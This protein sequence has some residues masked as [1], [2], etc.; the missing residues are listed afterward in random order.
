VSP[1]ASAHQQRS[2]SRPSDV[3]T[4][5][6]SRT[7]CAVEPH[8]SR[9]SAM[10][11]PRTGGESDPN[12]AAQSNSVLVSRPRSAADLLIAAMSMHPPPSIARAASCASSDIGMP[13]PVFVLPVVGLA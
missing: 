3:L 1:V 5:V 6:W 13:S 10:R 2:V 12:C 9:T 4:L 7:R 8:A 11:Q